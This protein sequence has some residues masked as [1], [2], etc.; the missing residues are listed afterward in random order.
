M[1][2]AARSFWRR[3]ARLRPPDEERHATWL[4]LFFDLCFVAAVA[5]LA[6]ELHSDPSLGGLLK[7]AGLFVPVWWAW[8]GFTWYASAFDNDDAVFRLYMLAA[9]LA[10]VALAANV[11][12]VDD[13][14]STGFVVS[15]AALKFLLA[16]MFVRARLHASEW[17]GFCDRYAASNALGAAVWLSSLAVSTPGRYWLWALGMAVLMTGPVIAVRSFEGI[18]FNQ[19]HI[20]ERYGLFTIIVL[21]ESI[22]VAST[23][24]AELGGEASVLVAAAAGFGLAACIWW[25]YFE[26]VGSSALSRESLLSS[27]LWGYGHMLVFS[28][29]A[30]AAVGVELVVEAASAGEPFAGDQ[31][32]TLALG[33]VAFLSAITVI[34]FVTVRAFDAVAIARAAAA[35][36][37]LG[38]A[39]SELDAVAAIGATLAVVVALVLF[40]SRRA[41][42]ALEP[43]A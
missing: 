28:G 17:R 24:I 40:E 8:M 27:F 19:A 35:L 42:A 18:A 22:V 41:A 32:W 34:H 4:E 37:L 23:G 39:M 16:A 38:L 7:F 25:M 13:G 9:M 31:R 12:G 3:P 21:G 30:A 1:N 15:Y 11:G 26:F 43:A 2:A 6:A 5:A 33:L 29:I 20:S 14:N 10:V 36:V